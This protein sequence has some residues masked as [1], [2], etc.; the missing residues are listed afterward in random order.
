MSRVIALGLG[1]ALILAGIVLLPAPGPFSLP[2][3]VVG[4]ALVLRSSLN[5]RRLYVRGRRRWPRTFAWIDRLLRR[6]REPVR[7]VLP[8]E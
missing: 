8:A 5:A 7:A 4:L 2:C 1:I 3:W 6:R